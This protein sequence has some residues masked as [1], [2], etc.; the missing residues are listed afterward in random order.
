MNHRRKNRPAE[1]LVEKTSIGKA[2]LIGKI[3]LAA[4]AAGGIAAHCLTWL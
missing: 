4:A 3:M 1:L 2:N